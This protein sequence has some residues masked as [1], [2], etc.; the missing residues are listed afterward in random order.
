MPDNMIIGVKPGMTGV[1]RTVTLKQTDADPESDTY[2]DLIPIDLT[3]WT[4]LAMIVSQE[5]GP[6]IINAACVADPDQVANEGKL[7][8]TFDSTPDAF[9]NI[10]IG[11]HQ[12]EFSGKDP[13]ED[14][15]IFPISIT[16]G[17]QFGTFTVSET[18]AD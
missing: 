9:P 2:G 11:E 10:V 15:H 8:C 18:W 12:L 5:N 13:D 4:E 6:V 14:L 16:G 3:G 17:R 7:S 1:V